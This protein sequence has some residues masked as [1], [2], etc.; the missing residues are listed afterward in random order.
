[1]VMNSDSFTNGFPRFRLRKMVNHNVEVKKEIFRC[2]RS[3]NV[4]IVN[5]ERNKKQFGYQYVLDF[6][7]R[8]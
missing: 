6:T 2:I 7:Q 1:M 5:S 3:R 8:N 4:T